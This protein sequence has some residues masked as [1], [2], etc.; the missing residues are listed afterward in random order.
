MTAL[1]RTLFRSRK[2]L[3]APPH[4]TAFVVCK[5][6]LSWMQTPGCF[7]MPGL[8]QPEDWDSIAKSCVNDCISLADAIRSEGTSPSVS[9]L[10]KFD[11]L[12]DRLCGVLD[13]AELCRNV[14]PEP[15]FVMAAHEAYEQVTTVIQ[16]LNADRSIY[17][18]LSALYEQHQ[19]A[20]K[21]HLH[22]QLKLSQEDAIMVKSLKEDFERGGIHLP[23][24]QRDR[25]IKIQQQINTI[26]S[27]FSSTETQEPPVIQFPSRK[28]SNLPEK[29]R[30][31][32]KTSQAR[33]G[34]VDVPLTIS[35][36][37]MILK[38]AHES[39]IREQAYRLS[40]DKDS[41]REKMLDSLLSKRG[42]VAGILG[43]KSYA[44]LMFSN[45]LASSPSAV[46]E[47]LEQLSGMV[48]DLAVQEEKLLERAKRLGEPLSENSGSIYSWD[49]T[50]YIGRVKAQDLCLSS[51]ST[52]SYFPL[53]SCLRALSDIVKNVFGI[54]IMK[55]KADPSELWHTDVEKFQVVDEAQETLGHIFL[56]LY[57]REGKYNHA[58]HFSIRCGRQPSESS[59]YQKPVVALVC[60]F[61][62][63][64]DSGER[65]LTMSEYDTL[66][67]EF[68]HSIHSIL[69]RTKYQHLAGT[70]VSTDLVE[71]P[72]HIFE[73]FAW[74]PR[75]LAQY[76]RHYR[77][78]DAMP[79]R[80]VKAVSASRK[81][82]I[83]TDIQQQV[84]FA[85]MD[86]EFHGENAPIGATTASFDRLKDQLTVFQGDGGVA[87]P[88]SFHHF[89]GYGAGY[90]SYMFARILS[91]QVWSDLFSEDPFSREGGDRLRHGLLAHGAAKDST[92][93]I[94][95]V[96]SGDVTCEAFLG[97]IGV[98]TKDK[99]TL[100]LPLAERR[101]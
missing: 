46:H 10:Q 96:I 16:H 26:G 63:E 34:H 99:S 67:H 43:H 91:A 77:T 21:S 95:D 29:I 59:E 82:F 74:D 19:H 75:V 81:R 65:L 72:S 12:S 13:T 20:L 52:T 92:C 44:D 33:E 2:F 86:L 6:R 36:T 11:D 94:R 69:S 97:Q 89:I 32:W 40:P 14:H 71:V 54:S 8:H 7:G 18:P 3:N 87:V 53:Q 15:D 90:Y 50:F 100:R 41:K 56:D 64:S 30:S 68:G 76:A 93:L 79:T 61:G 17:D 28:I 70:R 39:N 83:G 24:A 60:N 88:A 78:G 73:H 55:M 80:V 42:E 49:R 25:L 37:Q 58:A 47:F 45:R 22:S 51:A 5:R 98:Q 101:D 48:A 23:Q 38:W 9:V 35:N 62:V 4:Q 31:V 85:A 84:L 1:S 27:K 66:F 57:P